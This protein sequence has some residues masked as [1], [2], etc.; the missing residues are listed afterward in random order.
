MN[1]LVKCLAVALLVLAVVAMDVGQADARR[2]GGG[3]SF[4]GSRS[5]NKSY[6]KPAPTQRQSATGSQASGAR[7]SRFGGMGGI[8]GGLLAGTLLGSLFFGHPFAGG[9][10]LDLLLI[11]GAI[12]LIMKLMRGRRPATQAAGRSGGMGYGGAGPDAGP[13]MRTGGASRAEQGWSN[14]GASPRPDE[15]PG[16]DVPP[17]FDEAEFLEGAKAL[18]NR[19]QTS[20]DARDLDDIRQ[21]TT[22]AVYD[23]VRS[24]AAADPQ[25]STTEVLMVD[26][27]L[28][29]VRTEGAATL[30]TVF[31]DA[32]MREEA[33]ASRSEQVREVWHFRREDGVAGGTWRLDGIQQLEQ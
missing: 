24:Q 2:F 17:G 27:R 33:V 8:F 14:L 25:P 13:S 12:F 1:T 30:A 15:R 19:M 23:E 31:F 3:R 21:F 10:M 9:G 22:D 20:W 4:G 11:G 28:L 32:Y 18:F 26:G 6:S 5:F 7:S 16:I 29:E